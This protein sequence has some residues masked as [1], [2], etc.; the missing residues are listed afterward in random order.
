MRPG[1]RVE[2]ARR[3]PPNGYPSA[4]LLGCYATSSANGTGPRSDAPETGVGPDIT[5]QAE[6]PST[7]DYRLFL[8]FKHGGEV[9]TAEFTVAAGS[10]VDGSDA[11]VE[12]QDGAPDEDDGA[13]SGHSH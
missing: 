3:S 4:S 11:P 5:F 9:R 1:S 7:G 8:D 12:D 10:T 13:K 2:H 6:V